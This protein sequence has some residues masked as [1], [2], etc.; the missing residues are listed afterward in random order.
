MAEQTERGV[1]SPTDLSG[2]GR[3][4]DPGRA[5][6]TKTQD[7]TAGLEGLSRTPGSQDLGEAS[8]SEDNGGAGGK[9]AELGR[10]RGGVLDGTSEGRA[11]EL[12][13]VV[14]GRGAGEWP[15]QGATK[16]TW[17]IQRQQRS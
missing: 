15:E 6:E 4:G 11:K 14:R 2:G 9:E 16:E 12:Q 5:K 7:D 10:T 13:G 17:Q 8:G 3:G 1:R